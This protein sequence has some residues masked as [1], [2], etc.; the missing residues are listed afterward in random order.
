LFLPTAF[1]NH[2]EAC[3]GLAGFPAN[4]SCAL[5]SSSLPVSTHAPAF[6]PAFCGAGVG[7]AATARAG[8]G[9]LLATPFAG[10]L[11]AAG[12]L[13]WACTSSTLAACCSGDCCGGC[14][15]GDCCAVSAAGAS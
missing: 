10:S 14:C 12:G 4:S 2:T 9:E 1:H 3:A 5:A 7:C 13:C 8:G 15:A 6:T 11:T